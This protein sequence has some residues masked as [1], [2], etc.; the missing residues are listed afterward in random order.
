MMRYA[1]K[2]MKKNEKTK[3]SHGPRAVATHQ[4]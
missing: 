2:K 4:E 3:A 1:P